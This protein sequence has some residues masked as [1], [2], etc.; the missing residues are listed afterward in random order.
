VSH[1]KPSD[2]QSY[3]PTRAAAPMA[4]ASLPTRST[5]E[6][7]DH[8]PDL[9]FQV[10]G[11]SHTFRSFAPDQWLVLFSY[12]KD[13]TP[14]CATEMA[15]LSKSHHEFVRRNAR[16]LGLCVGNEEEHRAFVKD[17]QE[18]FRVTVPLQV[19]PDV[20][21]DLSRRLGVIHPRMRGTAGGKHAV[22]SVIVA[23]P[24]GD[25]THR[26]VELLTHYPPHIGRDVGELLR[27]ID[28]LIRSHADDGIGT[29]A[30]WRAGEDVVI[31]PSVDDDEATRRY[32]SLMPSKFDQVAS[33]IRVIP[34]PGLP[35]KSDS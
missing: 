12:P 10:E 1:P 19:I 34:D 8:L 15:E 17:V 7:G 22:R 28:A 25:D 33:Y 26:T 16:L 21:G 13:M 20:T 23:T 6:L 35:A 11:V 30:N 18:R 32:G 3:T 24:V 14:V 4:A 2:G 5:I 27:C 29:P 31:L 9:P